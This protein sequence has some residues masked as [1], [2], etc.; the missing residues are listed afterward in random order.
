MTACLSFPFIRLLKHIKQ[1]SNNKP[2]T[3]KLNLAEFQHLGIFVEA[4]FYGTISVL[5][6]L[7]T[8]WLKQSNIASSQDSIPVYFF[9]IYNTM[10]PEKTGTIPFSML[11][12]F[13][14]FYPWSPLV[15]MSA[16]IWL[17]RQVR[18]SML[19]NSALMV[20]YRTSARMNIT[21]LL[22]F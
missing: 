14:I 6:L 10:H 12:V 22:L 15:L 5:L 21:T 3:M 17:P 19:F 9:C 7:C 8:E 13:Y 11:S 1:C 20:L 18:M 2:G 4:F 16:L